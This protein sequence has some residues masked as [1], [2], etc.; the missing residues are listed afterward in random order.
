MSTVLPDLPRALQPWQGW[1]GWFD[2]ALAPQ[3]GDMVRRLSELV[4]PSPSAGRAGT[5]EP[6]G[7][8]DLR[9]RGPYERLLASEWLL[10]EELPDEFLRRAVASE[11]LFLAPRLRARQVE[12]SVVALFDCGPRALGAARLAHIAAW[13]LLARRADD[14]GGSLRWGV[15]QQPGMLLPADSPEQLAMLMRA[16]SF[17]PATAAHVAQWRTALA[18]LDTAAE[19]ETWWVG[20]A[21]PGLPAPAAR[22]E[23]LLTLQPTF[24]GDALQARLDI[25]GAPRGV[26]LPLPGPAEA[27]ALLR[28]QF[29]TAAA[30]R[31]RPA[32]SMKATARLSL[33]QGLVM[34]VPPGHVA[35][36]ELGQHAMLVFAI[37][38]AGQHKLAKPRR[39]MW[40]S[41]QTPFAAG[42]QRG[43]AMAVL[44]DGDDL[45]FWQMP[46][47]VQ[48]RRPER[49]VF[50]ASAQ[51][52][53]WLPMLRLT[54]VGRQLTCVIDSARRLVAW[55][56]PHGRATPRQ[57]PPALD[58]LVVD[59]DVRVM[60]PLSPSRLVFAMV[61]GDGIWLRELD[62]NGQALP[63]G[64]RLCPAP[65]QVLDMAV[66]VTG[67]AQP[68]A[69][70]GS[71]ALAH[72]LG[73]QVVWQVFTI[74]REGRPLDAVDGAA[75]HEIA[76]A[77]GERG[78]GLV[79]QRGTTPPALVVQSADRKRLRLAVASGSSTLFESPA[80]IE[81]CSVCPISGKV[82]VLT[83]DRRLTVLDPVD[84]AALLVV[85]DDGPA[86]AQDTDGA[87]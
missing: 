44:G 47:F 7:L 86:D 80:P 42:L 81:R 39:Q 40:S 55:M 22:D 72:H 74:T 68:G 69:R 13:I 29:R 75:S 83:R 14:N 5:P 16:R 45:R 28:G 12:R 6:D 57:A 73:T 23:R 49:E 46:G 11:H 25:A 1:L 51:T 54:S 4:G 33:T 65:R 3:V 17:T 30:A 76:L 10:A 37:P 26:A 27:T 60:A 48:R 19:R 8:G 43:E 79:N 62:A 70:L 71:L 82:A 67:Y 15:L 77:P 78:L 36:P 85:A 53:R 35:V 32:P 9:S 66:A 63:L 52:A 56:A 24:A 61:Y 20:P 87:R 64:R 50:E 21:G 41:R 38:H 31:T 58:A 84:R 18:G 2:A 34:S 59:R